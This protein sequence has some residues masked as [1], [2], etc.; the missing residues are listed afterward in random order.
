M[1]RPCCVVMIKSF[2]KKNCDGK[3]SVGI[4][5]LLVYLFTFWLTDFTCILAYFIISFSYN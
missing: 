5:Y 1:S 3:I 2:L 4:E